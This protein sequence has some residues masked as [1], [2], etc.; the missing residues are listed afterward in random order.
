MTEIDLDP[1]ASEQSAGD[2]AVSRQPPGLRVLNIERGIGSASATFAAGPEHLNLKGMLHGGYIAGLMDVIMSIAAG[3]HPDPAQRR[4]SITLSLS[5]NFI[6]S[7]GPGILKLQAETVGGG[8]RTCFCEGRIKDGDG[9]TV[10]TAQGAFK[11]MEPG[12]EKPANS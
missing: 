5:L 11:L 7:A 1:V 10:A 2:P 12:T 8:R 6:G 9:N 3:S 4:F